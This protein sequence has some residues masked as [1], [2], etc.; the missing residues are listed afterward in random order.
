MNVAAAGRGAAGDQRPNA[1][2]RSIRS[3]ALRAHEFPAKQADGAPVR[4]CSFLSGVV[5]T[6]KVVPA[7]HGDFGDPFVPAPKRAGQGGC[8]A[9]DRFPHVLRVWA[10]FEVRNAIVRRVS[11]VV[12]DIAR[13][14]LAM[15]VEP[16][17]TMLITPHPVDPDRT[18]SAVARPRFASN[19]LPPR[20]RHP[21][22]EAAGPRKIFG[23]CQGSIVRFGNWRRQIFLDSGIL[24]RFKD[25]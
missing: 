1:S 14:V 20:S 17:E 22:S 19:G 24:F 15:H 21:P 12:I 18:I 25:S 2:R 4:G 9:P 8:I 3:A 10:M 23:Y 13:R 7:V 5:Y 16:C 6:E 11:V